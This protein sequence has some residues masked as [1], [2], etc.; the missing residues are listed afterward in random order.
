MLYFIFNLSLTL[1][2]KGVLVKFPHPYTLTALHALFGAIGGWSLWV[3][4]AFIPKRLGAADHVALLIF[5]VL[6]TMNIAVSNISLNLVTVPVHQVVRAA[7]PIFTLVLS[8]AMFEMKI[9]P[10]KLT[11]L[12]PVMVGVGLATYGDY[13]A[14]TWGLFLTLLGTFLAALKTIFTNVLQSNAAQLPRKSSSILMLPALSLHPLDLLLR[15]CPLAFIQCV[16]Y[17]HMSG[18]LDQVRQWSWH[19][20]TWLNFVGLF[21]N[22]CI[23]F[24]LNVVSFTANKKAG[25]LSMTVA[26]NIK[27]VLTIL[28]A[29]LLFNLNITFTN[30]VGIVFTLAGGAWYGYVDYDEKKRRRERLRTLNT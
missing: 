25:P 9:S 27:Q 22:G 6:Y 24:G 28:L 30:G 26:A 12:I 29:V 18:E 19:E 11:S 21:V 14:T 1:Y 16:F 20:M 10:R 7:T 23:A 8:S 2:N 13:Y 17:A 5:S 15:M 4:G 3:Q